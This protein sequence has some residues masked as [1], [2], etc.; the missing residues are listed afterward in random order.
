MN[1]AYFLSRIMAL[2]PCA[3]CPSLRCL[4]I[5]QLL[6]L[7]H[8]L[9]CLQQHSFFSATMC[10]CG[11]V[12]PNSGMLLPCPTTV[13][14]ECSVGPTFLLKVLKQ[15]L[16]KNCSWNNTREHD[17]CF[18]VSLSVRWAIEMELDIA[19]RGV[20]CASSIFHSPSIFHRRK[21]VWTKCYEVE[22]TNCE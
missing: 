1:E 4:C 22:K 11:E 18:S 15:C 16:K 14:H 12:W 2:F 5:C 8:C 6:S 13:L 10:G 20:F 21:T 9:L 3:C 17:V 7:F 19:R